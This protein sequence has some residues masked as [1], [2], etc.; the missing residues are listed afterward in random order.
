MKKT[1]RS[2]SGYKKKKY[3]YKKK[4]AYVKKV[5][6]RL[7]T[8]RNSP[9]FGSDQIRFYQMQFTTETLLPIGLAPGVDAQTV[10]SLIWQTFTPNTF[11]TT[12]GDERF[13][14]HMELSEY[15][16]MCRMQITVLPTQTQVN[17]P[18]GLNAMGQIIIVPLHSHGD[19]VT[20]GVA[21]ITLSQTEADRWAE[22]THAKQV[23]LNGG[24]I[25]PTY[26][27]ICPS[28]F[29]YHYTDASFGTSG[30]AST[31]TTE[32]T[33]GHW[34]ETRDYDGATFTFN[35]MIHYGAAVIFA[36]FDTPQTFQSYRIQYRFTFAFKGYDASSKLQPS[37]STAV[38][39]E[40][41]KQAEVV[42]Y[43]DLKSYHEADPRKRVWCDSGRI[44]FEEGK[45]VWRGSLE[46]RNRQIKRN[47]QLL[48]EDHYEEVDPPAQVSS[49]SKRTAPPSPAP[50]SSPN[51][52]LKRQFTNMRL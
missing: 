46:E 5:F 36:G 27:N 42:E 29:R 8:V 34:Y 50:Q 26:I 49:S 21:G 18:N 9:T 10:Q 14:R 12:S 4:S 51:P 43:Y 19:I 47:S 7:R 39:T 30:S 3:S 41:A 24:A 31:A 28:V 2:K 22:K 25:T 32:F 48:Y 52:H 16:R 1:K 33:K 37:P 44:D 15:F 40:D 35:K 20:S 11:A 23:R 6:K 17:V 45:E 13:R 38:A